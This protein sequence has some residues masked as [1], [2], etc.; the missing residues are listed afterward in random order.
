MITL[1]GEVPSLPVQ[2][3]SVVDVSANRV[4]P[5]AM[6]ELLRRLDLP[7]SEL[8]LDRVQGWL[9]AADDRVCVAMNGRSGGFRYSLRPLDEEPGRDITT[10]PQGL[11]DVAR[12]FLGGLGRP[13]EP[14]QLGHISYLR[15]QSVS[16]NGTV[17][18]AVETLNAA[19]TFQRFIEDIPVIGPGGCASVRVGTDGTVVGGSEVWRPVTASRPPAELIQPDEAVAQVVQRLSAR[20]LDGEIV[21]RKAQF[22]YEELGINTVQ[23]QLRPCFAFLLVV[24]GDM[25]FKTVEVIPAIR[26]QLA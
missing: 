11:E 10:S 20:G 17:L 25:P 21:V 9:A 12:T 8:E 19:V 18:S 26:P 7:A 15:G 5:G 3:A 6:I 16:A 1:T 13:A 2:Q 23:R 14:L 24:P 22:G 4:G